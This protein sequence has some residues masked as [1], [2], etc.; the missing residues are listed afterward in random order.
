MAYLNLMQDSIQN[1][2]WF[3]QNEFPHTGQTSEFMSQ[4]EF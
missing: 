1:L 3:D 2:G 4:G